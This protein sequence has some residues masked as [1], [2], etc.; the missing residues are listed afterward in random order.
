MT[1]RNKQPT[2]PP[3][4]SLPP[5]APPFTY[6]TLADALREH[7]DLVVSMQHVLWAP[8]KD[9]WRHLA[10]EIF[11]KCSTFK[12]DISASRWAMLLHSATEDQ[13][14]RAMRAQK[15]RWFA[16]PAE[17]LKAEF[18]RS[19]NLALIQ[20][21]LQH[22]DEPAARK[23]LARVLNIRRDLWDEDV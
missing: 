23:P 18:V 21:F 12:L 8:P 20:L 10:T 11:D 4:P 15:V 19:H 3:P 7:R 1:R 22:T 6:W 13:I 17:D 5:I 16:L 2:P 14:T 9:S